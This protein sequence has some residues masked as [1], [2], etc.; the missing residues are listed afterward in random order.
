MSTQI[1]K[2]SGRAPTLVALAMATTLCAGIAG[3][4][5]ATTPSQK[6]TDL[7]AQLE[8]TDIGAGQSVTAPKELS[9]GTII[10]WTILLTLGGLAATIS[11]G[12]LALRAGG[13]L[14]IENDKVVINPGVKQKWQKLTARL[15]R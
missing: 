6:I 9:R 1:D 14:D 13:V 4:A 2:T 5:H 11:G 7:R 8:C 10:A 12:Y 15:K 3:N